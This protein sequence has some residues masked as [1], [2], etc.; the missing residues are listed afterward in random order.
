[1]KQTLIS[2]LAIIGGFSVL[3]ASTIM[4]YLS[5]RRTI[6]S[7]KFRTALGEIRYKY[8]IALFILPAVIM[9]GVELGWQG[10]LFGLMV[11]LGLIVYIIILQ[12]LIGPV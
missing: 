12:W 10:A 9:G 2:I 4:I 1:M 11:G 7:M 5:Y 3:C 8:A 6:P